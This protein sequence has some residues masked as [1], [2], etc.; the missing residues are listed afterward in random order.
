MENI[1]DVVKEKNNLNYNLKISYN[2]ALKDEVFKKLTSSIN[3]SDDELMK[4]TSSFEDAAKE[5]K[6]C[7]KC[8]G[9]SECK[10]SVC[11]YCYLPVLK[12]KELIFSYVACRYKNKYINDNKYLDNITYF[13]VPKDIKEAKIK[14][15]YTDDKNREKVIKW[16]LSYIKDYKKGNAGNGLFLHGNFGCGKTYLISAMF[17]ELAKDKVK[18]VIIYYPEYLRSLKSSYGSSSKDE[19]KDKFNEVKYA[20]LLLIDDLGAEAV[21]AWERDEILGSILQYRMQEHL[22]TFITSN[23]NLKQLEDHLSVTTNNKSERVKAV[24]IIERIK[25][26]TIDMEMIGENNR[27]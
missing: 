22:P 2:E 6:N 13:D 3:L 17:N 25:Q 7:M 23:L 21:T 16:I 11:G 20:R 19:F 5:Y 14:N 9:L 8:K 18:S 12:E 1:K 4:Y 24:R 10:N 15:I 26:L 27:H